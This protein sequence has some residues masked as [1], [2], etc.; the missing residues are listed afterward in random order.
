[1]W[2]FADSSPENT[3]P[4]HPCSHRHR[5]WDSHSSL[6][7]CLCWDP[8]RG[9]GACRYCFA[10]AYHQVYFLAYSCY[11]TILRHSEVRPGGIL[12]LSSNDLY[13]RLPCFMRFFWH[14]SLALCSTRIYRHEGAVFPKLGYLLLYGLCGLEKVSKKT[15]S[16]SIL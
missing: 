5:V 6:Q 12:D 16:R 15:S 7:F 14:Y 4:L 13:H 9:R 2:S 1:M 3:N 11:C 8:W 10:Y